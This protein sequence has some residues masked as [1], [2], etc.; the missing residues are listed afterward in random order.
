[1]ANLKKYSNQELFNINQAKFSTQIGGIIDNPTNNQTTFL[2]P[3][4]SQYEVITDA[5]DRDGF[6]VGNQWTAYGTFSSVVSALGKKQVTTNGNSADQGMQLPWANMEDDLLTIGATYHLTIDVDL[7]SGTSDA[8]SGLWY[9]TIG[10]GTAVPLT[11][12]LGDQTAP[13]SVNST[14]Q[15]YYANISPAQDSG[16]LI[17]YCSAASN[18]NTVRVRFDNIS[19]IGSNGTNLTHHVDCSGY[20]YLQLYSDRAELFYSFSRLPKDITGARGSNSFNT[21]AQKL[22]NDPTFESS[23]GGWALAYETGSSGATLAADN[24]SNPINGSKD[25]KVTIAGD[26]GSAVGVYGPA[27]AVYAH[28]SYIMS[29]K[30]KTNWVGGS[31]P[32][33]LNARINGDSEYY[34]GETNNPNASFASDF[35]EGYNFYSFE[36]NGNFKADANKSNITSSDLTGWKVTNLD[37]SLNQIDQ[38]TGNLTFTTTGTQSGSHGFLFIRTDL[39]SDGNELFQ[40]GEKYLVRVVI[41]SISGCNP[42][43][44]DTGDFPIRV[45][46]VGVNVFEWEPSEG[47]WTENGIAAVIRR[48]DGIGNFVINSIQIRNADIATK[49]YALDLTNGG[50]LTQDAETCYMMFTTTK[51]DTIRPF[52]WMDNTTSNDS[53]FQIDDIALYEYQNQTLKFSSNDLMIPSEGTNLIPIPDLGSSKVYFNCLNDWQSNNTVIRYK[54][55]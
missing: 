55:I 45:L 4:S 21:G 54:L 36:T 29:F 27:V 13:G 18:D 11:A 8:D 48:D 41:A 9:A 46:E 3:D 2:R 26:H 35:C 23:S 14:D 40:L 49:P 1:M 37:S 16:Y 19:L 24:T 34:I 43:F 22:S 53:I 50:D 12:V 31:Q 51:G 6:G 15:T 28:K 5:L 7:I 20:K 33:M 17:I 30:Y 38:G 47:A 10:G 25:L 39:D 42:I 44:E 52:F 32:D